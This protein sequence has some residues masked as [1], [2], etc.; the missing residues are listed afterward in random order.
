MVIP[1]L[2]LL[3]VMSPGRASAAP[4]EA[5]VEQPKD[6]AP[7]K[8]C[9]KESDDYSLT[10]KEL[11]SVSLSRFDGDK[12]L[13][14]KAKDAAARARDLA[15]NELARCAATAAK[16]SDSCARKLKDLA[17]AEADY[18]NPG[19]QDTDGELTRKTHAAAR[20]LE[21]CLRD[22]EVEVP[23]GFVDANRDRF[24]KADAAPKGGKP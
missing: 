3:L 17:A 2:G 6:E 13:Y 22:A 1:L 11:S 5:A 16:K 8:P 14:A 15:R 7:V 10:G 4:A 18:D 19:M 24:V 20:E 23:K 21:A 9:S 12:E